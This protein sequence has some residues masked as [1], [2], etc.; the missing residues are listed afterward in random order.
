MSMRFGPVFL[1]MYEACRRVRTPE[2][3]R[4]IVANAAAPMAKGYLVSYDVCLRGVSREKCRQWLGGT[5]ERGGP[6]W[7]L[8]ISIGAA[9][10]I[11][12]RIF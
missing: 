5:E 4:Q 2:Q 3:C 6:P 7:A 8:I 11:L 1:D 10:L 12:K 9:F